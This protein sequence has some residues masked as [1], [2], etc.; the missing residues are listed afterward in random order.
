M[1][2]TS[3]GHQHEG[4]GNHHLMMTLLDLYSY[5]LTGRR[6]SQD[7]LPEML[8][9][10]RRYDRKPLLG[11]ESK[12]L[13]RARDS[14]DDFTPFRVAL[15][16]LTHSSIPEPTSRRLQYAETLIARAPE[17]LNAAGMWRCVC[18][19]AEL[20]VL[21]NPR[22]DR[23]ERASIRTIFR[24]WRTLGTRRQP[25]SP[26]NIVEQIV[27]SLTVIAGAHAQLFDAVIPRDRLSPEIENDSFHA[28]LPALSADGRSFQP[29]RYRWI[30]WI[31]EDIAQQCNA[32]KP[33]GRYEQAEIIADAIELCGHPEQ[34][35]NTIAKNLQRLLAADSFGIESSKK[36]KPLSVKQLCHYFCPEP[37]DQP[38]S[39]IRIRLESSIAWLEVVDDIQYELA[40]AGVEPQR[41]VDAFSQ[42]EL[43]RA[44]TLEHFDNVM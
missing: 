31:L 13:Q 26:E 14:E 41:I 25:F 10:I 3:G 7:G 19:S 34:N 43:H 37:P 21:A 8:R 24:R 12:R 6:Q 38:A 5:A 4:L 17:T 22:F 28:F 23:H 9:L 30:T 16:I 1:A 29:S 2:K 40:R 33:S 18:C 11:K 15:E 35:V 32:S 36:R 27:E 42:M 44:R 39:A 20:G